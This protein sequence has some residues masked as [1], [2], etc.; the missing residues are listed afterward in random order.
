MFLIT[1]RVQYHNA[2]G[3][4]VPDNVFDAHKSRD[5]TLTPSMIRC[6]DCI[7]FMKDEVGNG[8]GIGF[9]RAYLKG[10]WAYAKHNCMEYMP[11]EKV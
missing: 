11:V 2:P 9:C 4:K 6:I 7:H 10:D 5:R 3:G 1:C 8:S